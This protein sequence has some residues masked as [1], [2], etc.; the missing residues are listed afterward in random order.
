MIGYLPDVGVRDGIVLGR[1][2]REG[3]QRGWGLQFGGL[4]DR[5][6]L[7]GLY[8]RALADT[9]ITP[10]VTEE[11][12]MNLYLLMTK[13]LPTL[14]HRNIV[15]F[16]SYRGG[17]ALF[18]ANVMREVDPS[19]VVYALDTYAGMPETDKQIDA[20]NG[21]DFADAALN[22]LRATIADLKLEN[23]V[24][25]QGLFHQ[26]FPA[27]AEKTK[28]GLAHIDADIYSSVR[29]AQD[30]VW[31]CMTRGGYVVFD[32]AE[33]SSCLGATQAVEE[34]IIERRIHSEQI[35]PHFVFRAGL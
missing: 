24:P 26:T 13:F 25:V 9:R 33:V 31:P 20:H 32:D 19:A 15:E 14:V 3:Y 16:G 2:P 10:W 30:A 34:L 21:G 29:Y 28:F 12:R 8:Q 11:K 22:E 17:T 6:K 1:S 18:M 7:D 4:A 35:W 27:L 23:L 5:V